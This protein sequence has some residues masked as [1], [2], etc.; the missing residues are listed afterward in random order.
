MSTTHSKPKSSVFNPES[1]P[2]TGLLGSR[3]L[4]SVG[5]FMSSHFTFSAGFGSLEIYEG[6]ELPSIDH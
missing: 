1:Y 2:T 4:G 6:M 5:E 3:Y